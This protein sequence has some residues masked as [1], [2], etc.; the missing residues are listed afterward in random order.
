MVNSV[1][2]RSVYVVT[3]LSY[4]RSVA[5]IQSAPETVVA[6]LAL[7]VLAALCHV[8]M[9]MILR[10]RLLS[11]V[12]IRL[13]LLPAQHCSHFISRLLLC[14]AARCPLC[15]CLA[16]LQFLPSVQQSVVP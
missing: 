14:K 7:A 11:V 10:F 3:P 15:A 13:P 9:I 1:G 5:V 2:S 8:R 6:A 12:L 16:V 4:M